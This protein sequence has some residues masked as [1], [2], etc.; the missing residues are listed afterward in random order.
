[1]RILGVDPGTRRC[2]Y[3]VLDVEGMELRYVECGVIEPPAKAPLAARLGELAVSL[4][5]VIVELRPGEVAVEEVFHGVD[6]SAALRLGHARGVILA[7]AGEAG[8]PVVGYPP[9]KIK[10]AVTGRGAAGKP[11]VAGVVRSLLGLR[12]TPAP[13]A[14][15]AL[16][17]AI[18][19]AFHRSL[20]ARIGRATG[21]ADKVAGASPAGR[22]R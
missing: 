20:A 3:G 18:C 9:A 7:V 5:E 16:A 22:A 17:A 12:R 13:D 19:H 2:G 11:Q 10:K 15:D 14:A 4:R 8:L 1:M 21:G 6:A